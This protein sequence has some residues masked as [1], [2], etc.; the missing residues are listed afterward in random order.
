MRMRCWCDRCGLSVEVPDGGWPADTQFVCKP[1]L[2]VLDAD[3]KG[4]RLMPEQG[5]GAG[6]LRGDARYERLR[7]MAAERI[8]RGMADERAKRQAAEKR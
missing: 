3:V 2:D 6:I 4:I 5:L 1:C 7:T 8:D